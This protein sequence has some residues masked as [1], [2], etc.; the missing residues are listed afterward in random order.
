MTTKFHVLI[1][2]LCFLVGIASGQEKL[3][4]IEQLQ[5]SAAV[6][7][8]ATM[9]LVHTDWCTYCALQKKQLKDGTLAHEGV[10]FAEFN[11]EQNKDVSFKGEVYPFKPTGKGTGMHGLVEYFVQGKHVSFPLWVILDKELNVLDSY[12][13]YLRPEELER[14][15]EVLGEE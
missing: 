5:D 3:L 15:V 12:T 14:I 10:Y 1:M 9:L 7:P 6:Q 13:G 2:S 4:T 11:A 8:K